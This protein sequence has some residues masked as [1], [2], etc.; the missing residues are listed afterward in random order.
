MLLTEPGASHRFGLVGPF[1]FRVYGSGCVG[2]LFRVSGL[3]FRVQGL[4]AL[5]IC[6]EL[7]F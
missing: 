2:L 7:T 6:G 1:E 5:K 3:G 4:A